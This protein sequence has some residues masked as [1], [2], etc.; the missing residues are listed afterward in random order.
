MSAE[1]AHRIMGHT[2]PEVMRN[3][4]KSVY[5]IKLEGGTS[6][7]DSLQCEACALAKPTQI[8]SCRFETEETIGKVPGESWLWDLIYEVLAYNGSRYVS[9]FQDLNTKF[10]LVY[11]QESTGQTLE[12]MKEAFNLIKNK[13]GCTPKHILLDRERT[14][15]ARWKEL[16]T[17]LGVEERRTTPDSPQQSKAERA[18]RMLTI[19]ARAMMVE[20]RMP[21]EMWPEAYMTAGY[22]GNRT[23]IQRLTWRTPFEGLTKDVPMIGHMHSYECKAY[24][25]EHHIPALDKILPRAHIGY[26]MGY[27]ST[28]I[29][30]IWMSTEGKVICTR[31]V[32]FDDESRYN[33]EDL[34][35]GTLKEARRY[36]EILEIP[37][38]S[39]RLRELGRNQTESDSDES[40]I[41]VLDTSQYERRHRQ[42]E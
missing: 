24:V 2:E 4:E 22:V 28:S 35:L 15:Q 41:I 30:R 8:V 27:D 3:L 9:H 7:P 5:G 17:D 42:E 16:L 21:A 14:L 12:V 29:F 13:Y 33:P 32:R 31:D 36:I 10:N 40:D 37:E 11:T 23:P 26:F 20:V 1:L 34:E 25:V 39:N 19:K 38:V 6:P 18:E